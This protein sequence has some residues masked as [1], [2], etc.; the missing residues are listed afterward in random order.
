MPRRR[1]IDTVH[2]FPYG[3]LGVAAA[4][5]HPAA[6]ISGGCRVQA[7]SRPHGRE[8]AARVAVPVRRTPRSGEGSARRF[9]APPRHRAC[10]GHQ[11]GPGARAERTPPMDPLPRARYGVLCGR[12]TDRPRD[13]A[14]HFLR[15][16]APR[17]AR[18]LRSQPDPS[19]DGRERTEPGELTRRYARAC[20]A[21]VYARPADWLWTYRRWRF[22][23]PLYGPD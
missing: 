1:P 4:R 15:H 18:L 11:R 22:P 8:I 10:A 16:H 23:K 21:D 12:G 6:G 2:D 5:G 17:A 9:P 7:D 19:L 20:E 3:Q 13:A 14:S